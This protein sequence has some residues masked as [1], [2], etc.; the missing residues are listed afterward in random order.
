MQWTEKCD[1]THINVKGEISNVI[2]PQGVLLAIRITRLSLNQIYISMC[3][4]NRT[5]P[6]HWIPSITLS[7]WI[8]SQHWIS[9]CVNNIWHV[10]LFDIRNGISICTCFLISCLK[11][12]YFEL[13]QYIRF[14]FPPSKIILFPFSWR[15]YSFYRD[16]IG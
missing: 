8:I 10:D 12:V 13:N 16:G 1:E 14:T 3:L 6:M 5:Q 7:F 9:K 15:F 4:Q 11:C 2:F